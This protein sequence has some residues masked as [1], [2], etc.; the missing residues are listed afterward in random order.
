M[1]VEIWTD[2]VCP[3][4]YIGKRRFEK[5]LAGFEHRDEVKVIWRS[6][7]LDPDAPQS[8]GMSLDQ[9]LAQKYGITEAEAR[10]THERVTALAAAEG[11]SYRFDIA[12]VGNT[13]AA[14]RLV[15]LAETQGLAGA[16]EERLMK[17]YFT[18]GLAI[19]DTETLIRL[20]VEAGVDAAMA[21]TAL[22]DSG[23]AEEVRFDEA[24]AAQFGIT[25]V[26]FFAI[27]EHW[28]ISGAQPREVFREALSTSWK[29]IGKSAVEQA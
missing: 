20:G 17:A 28:G 16:M 7:E 9:R 1:T 18:E 8:L 10:A 5:A 21:R 14:H 3:W 12:Q 27:E 15:H 2:I 29:E 13:F 24:R 26:P 22:E 23:F 4:C 6:F 19:S 25:G 11:I